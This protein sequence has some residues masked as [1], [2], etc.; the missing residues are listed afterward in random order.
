[1]IKTKQFTKTASL[2]EKYYAEGKITKAQYD[3][4]LDKILKQ[5]TRDK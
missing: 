4:E 2:V 5:L 3:K 1:V